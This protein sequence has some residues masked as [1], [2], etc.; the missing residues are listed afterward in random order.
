MSSVATQL[1]SY[2]TKDG[3]KVIERFFTVPLDYSKPEGEKIRVFARSVIPK[4][5]AKT[6]EEEAKLPYVVYLQGGPGF[7]IGLMGNSGYTKE[8]HE[9]GYQTLWVDQRGTGL[10][11]SL[12][13][14][15]LPNHVKTDKEIAQYLK[16]FRADN[17]V[18]DCEFIRNELL[19]H[20]ESPEDRKWSLMG[21]SFGGFCIITYLSFSSAGLKEVFITERVIKR[22]EVYYK[23]YPQDVKRVCIRASSSAPKLLTQSHFKV[24]NI[25][26]F[27][28]SHTVTLPNGGRLSPTRFQ[29]LGLEFGMHGGI[30]RIHQIVFRA[31]S[32]L[33]LIKK[34]SYK[35]LQTIQQL[36][37]LDGNPLKAPNWSA[38]RTVQK[39]NC[40][41]WSHIKVQDD[42]T[43]VYFVG[44]M[45]FPETFD[46]Y[47]NLRP[48]KG[49]A[50]ILAEDDSWGPLYDLDQL[51]RN[52]VKVSAVTYFNDMYVD[53]DFAQQT[54]S[55]IKNTEQYITNQLVHDGIRE[56]PADIM[57]TLFRLSERAFD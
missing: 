44:E 51:A 23:K 14:D 39:H 12:T 30:D 1:E 45:I 53:F 35:T 20:K 57:K 6:A 10:S 31:A 26:A 32:D 15:T 38:S 9:K 49:A 28:E 3:L 37:G 52:D 7:E 4:A 41:S 5:K 22:N 2:D 47:A 29:Q 55:V 40:F 43:A 50:E 17:I 13:P 56:D 8:L 19:G 46:D 54:A 11:T 42:S 21:Q 24:R 33:D 48:W 36:Q 34:I 27:L 18:R 25:L 16:H